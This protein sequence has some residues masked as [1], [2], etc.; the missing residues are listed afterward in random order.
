LAD[1]FPSQKFVHVTS[2]MKAKLEK[3]HRNIDK[4]LENIIDEHRKNQMSASAE[5]E[6]L[7]DVLLGLQQS[8][9][10]LEFLI[11]TNNIKAVILVSI[12][13]TI[14]IIQNELIPNDL[15]S[16]ASVAIIIFL[17]FVKY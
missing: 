14:I 9:T 4:I 12:S 7:V 5:Q 13:A 17:V 8:G 2:G 16:I 15:G 1:Y 11:T 3:I 6:D 10:A